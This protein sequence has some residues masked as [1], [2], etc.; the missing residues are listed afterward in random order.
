MLVAKLIMGLILI[1]T[2]GLGIAC[3]VP[4]LDT[5]GWSATLLTLFVF[6]S[7]IY[8]VL[9]SDKIKT[10]YLCAIV[11]VAFTVFCFSYFDSGQMFVE[12]VRIYKLVN[13]EKIYSTVQSISNIFWLGFVLITTAE[14]Y[15]KPESKL[16]IPWKIYAVFALINC[17]VVVKH[18]I[19]VI[20][21]TTGPIH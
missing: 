13:N 4:K 21:I 1:A 2:M 14:L 16:S 6:V 18:L 17:V 11:T 8:K 7:S 20:S 3:F 15:R 10:V 19:W 9:N 12:Y 5:F